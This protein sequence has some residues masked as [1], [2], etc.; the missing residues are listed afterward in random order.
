MVTDDSEAPAE[1]HICT[2]TTGIAGK[3]NLHLYM[4]WVDAEAMRI[5]RMET[6]GT[7]EVSGG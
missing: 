7:Y 4:W 1:G 3:L 2:F 6:R 5:V